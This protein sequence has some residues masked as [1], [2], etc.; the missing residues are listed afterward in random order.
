MICGAGLS[1]RVGGHRIHPRMLEPCT[2]QP[3]DVR[4]GLALKAEVPL[5]A[6]RV[7]NARSI[8]APNGLA[9]DAE[10]ML[11]RVVVERHRVDTNRS[12]ALATERMPVHGGVRGSG[13]FL[14]SGQRGYVRDRCDGAR[15]RR[16]RIARRGG[17]A[18]RR[19]GG[20]GR[21]TAQR[22]RPEHEADGERDDPWSPSR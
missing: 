19:A 6:G 7:H 4:V 12:G 9:R 1:P 17:R 8:D 14:R 5:L 22:Y 11:A 10:R 18:R 3:L 21:R 15:H 20:H 16:V 13:G 2:E